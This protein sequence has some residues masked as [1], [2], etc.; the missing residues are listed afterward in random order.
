MYIRHLVLKIFCLKFAKILIPP[1]Q[2]ILPAHL[3]VATRRDSIGSYSQARETNKKNTEPLT[4]KGHLRL[5]T[6]AKLTS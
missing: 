2:D 5:G 4:E 3:K 6:Y 1:L